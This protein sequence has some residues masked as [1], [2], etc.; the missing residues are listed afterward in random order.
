MIRSFSN[1]M[2]KLAAEEA[3][4]NAAIEKARN[5][6]VDFVDKFAAEAEI[7]YA[8]VE[9]FFTDYTEI[10]NSY[11]EFMVNEEE[12]TEK[13]TLIAEIYRRGIEKKIPSEASEVFRNYFA[14][15]RNV[16]EGYG[17]PDFIQWYLDDSWVLDEDGEFIPP[18]Y[19][20]IFK[21]TLILYK[22]YWIE[23]KR[24]ASE[25]CVDKQHI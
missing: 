1:Y 18:E 12:F 24:L 2:D 10:I 25:K 17:V 21:A 20:D 16:I 9:D 3:A 19:P 13:K 4:H 7:G 8:I 15:L 5:E 14:E 23:L 11:L 22:E 6:F